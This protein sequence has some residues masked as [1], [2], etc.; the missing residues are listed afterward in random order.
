MVS[1]FSSN[2]QGANVPKLRFPEFTDEWKKE[3]L[4]DFA[5]RVTRKNKNNETTLPLTIS[6]KDGLV[7][8][9]TYFNK[10]VSSKDMSGYYL[11]KNGEFAYNKSYSV[12]FDYGSIKR[13]DN[14]PMG[15]LS[16][17]YICFAIKKHDSDFMKTYF[18]SLKW[19]K[20][21]YM[22]AAEGARN[23]GLL[24]IPTE[25]FFETVHFLPMSRKEQRTIA[26]FLLLINDRIQRQEQLVN[27]LKLYKRGVLKRVF[28][29]TS[30]WQMRK[31]KEIAKINT[32]SSNT[33]DS[34]PD[35]TYPFF[36]RSQ[37]V[38]KSNKYLYDCEAVLTIGDGQIG[39]V[40]HYI[41]GKFD[42]HQRVY[43]MSNFKEVTGR[44]FYHYFSTFFLDRAMRMSAKN[45]VD[46]VRLEMIGR[47]S[48]FL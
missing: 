1:A 6:S 42:C 45:T 23:H 36:I 39:K 2:S 10:Q 22:I 12:G 37:N 13:L 20:E 17:L 5:E 43:M 40:F 8:Q 29:N 38:A 25:D 47:V 18:D 35:G 32:G 33:Q 31:I 30:T 14:Y 4:S 48:L 19:Y 11:L 46:S 24:N 28:D 41:N 16:T 44:Y 7:D 27:S 21:I 9:I 15:A 3:R 26:D 34:D